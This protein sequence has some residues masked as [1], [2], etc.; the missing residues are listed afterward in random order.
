MRVL[1]LLLVVFSLSLA[2]SGAMGE[3]DG[4][5]SNDNATRAVAGWYGADSIDVTGF[6]GDTIVIDSVFGHGTVAR[7]FINLTGSDG[8]VVCEDLR[9]K[10]VRWPAPSLG[11]T[12]LTPTIRRILKAGT[13]GTIIVKYQKVNQ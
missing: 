3:I 9:G 5:Q 10:W 1:L 4:F 6:T 7:E 11:S 12:G 13:V 2:R 8:F